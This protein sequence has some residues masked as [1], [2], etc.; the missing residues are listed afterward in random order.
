MHMCFYGNPGTGKTEVARIIAGILYENK[1]L[2]TDKVIE[3]DRSGVVAGYV[4]QTAMKTMDKVMDAMGGVLFIDEAYSLVQS[5]SNGDYGHEA[6]ATLIK[7]ME[8][9][10]GKFSVILAGYRNSMQEMIATNPGFQSRIQFELDFPNYS[11]DELRQI[12]EQ[13]LK[14]RKYTISQQAMEKLLD[15]TDVKRKDPNFANAREIRNI[16]DQVVMC[17]NLRCTGTEDRELAL[18]DVNSY[19]K[20][21]KINL[22][23]SG[24]GFSKKILTAEE[25]LDRLIGLSSIKRMVKKIK[26]YAKRNKDDESFNM[27]MCFYGNPGTGKTEVARILS[28][29]LYDAGVLPEAKLTETD[30]HGLI[31][32]YVGETA[33]KTL[34]KINDAMGGVLFIDEAYSLVNAGGTDGASIGYGEEAIAVLLKEMEDR[35]GQFCVILAGYKEEMKS[36][37][38]SNPGLESRIQFQLDFPDHTREELGEIAKGFLEKKQY[39]I[40]EDVLS[41]VL[42][43][44]EYYRNRSNFA[45]ART[46]RNILEQVIMNQ[47]LRTEETGDSNII[48]S[49]VENYIMDEGID[50]SDT[51]RRP[52]KIGF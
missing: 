50:L 39:V 38:S 10:R 7:A 35:R 47:N 22:P 29:I 13:M 44:T 45:N 8:D 37:L 28:R 17:Q 23:T 11:R 27:H 30:S 40:T 6:V 12:A 4:G 25:E 9:Y 15:V 43:I 21:A 16:L 46:V 18:V 34:A 14:K 26:A 42:D 33:P 32:R 5:D 31:G 52:G 41:L 49:D 20:D 19:I 36:M 48:R 1:L 2:P 24:T 3:T 51:G